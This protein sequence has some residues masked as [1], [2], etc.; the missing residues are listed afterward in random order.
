MWL[1]YC[2]PIGTLAVT[3]PSKDE[4]LTKARNFENAK[5]LSQKQ[6]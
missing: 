6:T 5:N 4:K 2:P 3:S 1:E